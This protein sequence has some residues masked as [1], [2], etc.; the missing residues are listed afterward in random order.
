[1]C[2][3]FN[4]LDALEEICPRLDSL[5]FVE[6]RKHFWLI[7]DLFPQLG[8]SKQLQSP[9][10]WVTNLVFNLYF[11][12][13]VRRILIHISAFAFIDRKLTLISTRLDSSFSP[14]L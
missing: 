14:V 1:M 8:F 6:Q 4:N 9:Q 3:L 10:A 2:R 13:H 11:V 5:S 12:L 7:Q